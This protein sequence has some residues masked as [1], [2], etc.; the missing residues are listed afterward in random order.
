MQQINAAKGAFYLQRKPETV[1]QMV[2][3]PQGK[4]RRLKPNHLHKRVFHDEKE[5]QRLKTR[6][7][8][9]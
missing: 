3:Y 1:E 4:K 8:T 2:K 5:T 7:W 9:I 6:K